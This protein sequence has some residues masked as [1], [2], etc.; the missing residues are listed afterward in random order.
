MR[1]NQQGVVVAVAVDHSPDHASGAGDSLLDGFGAGDDGPPSHP[2]ELLGH[3]GVLI[4]D[5]VP[6]KAGEGAHVDLLEIVPELDGDRP[7]ARDHLGR[8]SRTFLRAGVDMS[9]LKPLALEPTGE[10]SGLLSS[11]R[12]EL[13][14]AASLP[15]ALGVG[16]RLGVSYQHESHGAARRARALRAIAN[17]VSTRLEDDLS[18]SPGGC[19]RAGDI[20]RPELAGGAHSTGVI[21]PLSSASISATKS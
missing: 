1:D 5:L 3:F 13:E 7:G 6:R 18:A 19:R 14:L 12:R 21:L 4:G 16:R 2:T 9:R 10:P 15:P 20:A 17:S 11:F 8:L